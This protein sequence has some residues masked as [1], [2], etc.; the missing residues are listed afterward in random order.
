MRHTIIILLS[1]VAALL[2]TSCRSVTEVAYL[3]D[4]QRDSAQAIVNTYQTTVHPGDLLYI[5]VSSQTPEA[6]IPFNQ[7]TRTV[8][9]QLSKVNVLD[10]THRSLISERQM[11]ST[12]SDIRYMDN[13]GYLVDEAGIIELPVL[14]KMKVAGLSIEDLQS[15]IEDRLKNEG[16]INDAVVTVSPM[17]FRVSVVGEVAR[18]QE[19]H[20]TGNRLTIL[21]ALAMCGDLAMD[22]QRDNVVVLRSKNGVSTPIVMDLT[23]KDFLDSDGYY[24]QTN[25]IVYVEPNK[26][27]KKIAVQDETWPKYA[28]FWVSVG[29]AVVNIG[30]ATLNIIKY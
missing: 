15:R 9:A 19:L 26:R 18:P 2:S 4:A 23:K 5:Y 25:D 21:E 11:S 1:I 28:E 13:N 27:K 29:V 24:L 30:Q 8:T 10:T 3:S 6:T 16:Y 17:N 20:I 7:D 14:G 22:A 12:A